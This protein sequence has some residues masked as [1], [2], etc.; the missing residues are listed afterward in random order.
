VTYAPGRTPA[1]AAWDLGFT[2]TTSSR[3]PS[4]RVTTPMG[5][6]TDKTSVECHNHE[7]ELDDLVWPFISPQL[8]SFDFF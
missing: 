6:S 1:S 7:M 2:P 3:S 8:H 4:A 5:S